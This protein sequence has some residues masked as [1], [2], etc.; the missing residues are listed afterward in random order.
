M[1]AEKRFKYFVIA[2]FGMNSG[3]LEQRIFEIGSAIIEEAKKAKKFSIDK[4]VFEMCM[5]HLQAK[6][7]LL[8][9]IDVLPSLK[10]KK[11]VLKHL[12]EYLLDENVGLGFI[13][14][15]TR[16]ASIMGKAIPSVV[17]PAINYSA[18][19]MA[20]NFL[21][22]DN[23][24][25]TVKI[26]QNLS[27][28]GTEF[29]IDA[30]GEKTTSNSE[31]DSC[32]VNYLGIFDVLSAEFGVNAKDKYGKSKIHASMKLSSLCPKFDPTDIHGTSQ[33][34]K[35]RLRPILRKAQKVG[36]AVNIDTEQH[37]TK[38]MT[39]V[40]FKEL[41]EEAE[42][43][44]YIDAAIVVQAYLKD[45]EDTLRDLVSWSEKNNHPITIRLVK[46][47]YW[48]H[49]VMLAQRN[50]WDAP[51]FSKKQESDA[52][53]ENLTNILL[54]HNNYVHA[55]IASH[56][57]RSMANALALKENK[58]IGNN[59][60]EIQMLYGMGDEIKKTLVGMDVPLRVYAPFGNL[61]SGM[62]YF[63][64]R[65]LENSANESFLRAFDADA[66]P[67]KLLINPLDDTLHGGC[68]NAR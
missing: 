42:F 45:S 26:L 38:E 23:I 63:V 61:I 53:Y 13:G 19:R 4:K 22:A 50:S 5:K 58:S 55:A 41:L 32:M 25:G 7:Q 17:V 15:G 54:G 36:A 47:A 48:D 33:A 34:I 14:K 44:D 9:F 18:K 21:A 2:C 52:N 65:L 28:K 59:S 35:S 27:N 46:G 10:D 6:T 8:R 57:I 39:N 49:E 1:R 16:L 64:R 31:A 24:E 30:L 60:F 67:K 12:E 56:N 62:G 68:K 11:D 66:D 20:K 37:Y 40:I 43:H 29:S 51:V 3:Q